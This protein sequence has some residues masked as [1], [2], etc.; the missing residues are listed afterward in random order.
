MYVQ[1]NE[2]ASFGF[3]YDQSLDWTENSRR[4]AYAICAAKDQD[5][6]A[7]ATSGIVAPPLGS[8]DADALIN[9]ARDEAAETVKY[10]ETEHDQESFAKSNPAKGIAKIRLDENI[11]FDHSLLAVSVQHRG[12]TSLRHP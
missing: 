11:G 9:W 7:Y 4:R 6:L 5:V 3:E 10:F 1:T 12:S 2:N 8:T